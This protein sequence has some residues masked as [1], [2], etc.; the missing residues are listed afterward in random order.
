MLDIFGVH[1]SKTDGL[2][3]LRK[4]EEVDGVFSEVNGI[5]LLHYNLMICPYAR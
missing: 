4:G 1:G 2:E 5:L 3:I